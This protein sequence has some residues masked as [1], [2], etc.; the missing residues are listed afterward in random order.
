CYLDQDGKPTCASTGICDVCNGPLGMFFDPSI[1]PSTT[2]ANTFTC[3]N[4]LQCYKDN[5]L[6]T[7]DLA[8]GC[9]QVS[10]CQDYYSKDACETNKCLTETDGDRCKWKPLYG[11]LGFGLCV[12]KD[13]EKI[14][15]SMCGGRIY[16]KS[17]A[18]KDVKP[19]DYYSKA[20]D[21]CTADYCM[22]LNP[23]G[24]NV[25]YYGGS[26]IVLARMIS[27]ASTMAT[28]MTA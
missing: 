4:L 13:P 15:C 24:T 17:I 9:D 25:C 22:T 12:D 2:N 10:S 7:V 20:L 11:E 18:K 26:A 28:R 5:S 1:I 8:R 19:Y 6:T 21:L 16:N 23:E 14:D 27:A 3:E